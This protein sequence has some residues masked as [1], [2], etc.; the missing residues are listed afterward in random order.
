M[1][2][3]VVA[4]YYK[5]IRWILLITILLYQ[6]R[7]NLFKFISLNANI[8]NKSNLTLMLCNEIFIKW[9]KMYSK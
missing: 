6:I 2:S 5:I 4:T 8:Y 3:K 7:K 9:I 1:E